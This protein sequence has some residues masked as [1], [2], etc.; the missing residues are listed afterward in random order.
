VEPA[1]SGDGECI[2][3]IERI[4]CV[5]SAVLICGAQRDRADRYRAAGLSEEYS[6]SAD[7]EVWSDRPQ[8]CAGRKAANAGVETAAE[9]E[10][11]I[12]TEQLIGV[13][14]L[15]RDPRRRRAGGRS[16]I[17]SQHG[18]GIEGIDELGSI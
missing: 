16:I 18:I 10:L 8:F 11:V 15:H 17:L 13:G 12:M 5:N 9:H 6:A 7:D 4:E 14:G 3:H 2:R 1:A